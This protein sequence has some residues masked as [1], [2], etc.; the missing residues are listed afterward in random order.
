MPGDKVKFGVLITNQG[1]EVA[2]GRIGVELYASP[3]RVLGAGDVRVGRTGDDGACV[4]RGLTPG[5]LR[6]AAFTDRSLPSV[7]E[8]EGVA[9]EVA[10]ADVRL[11]VFV[12]PEG[13][14][15]KDPTQFAETQ[16]EAD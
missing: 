15:L 2:V 7:V 1:D 5:R 3:D 8:T 9:G 16:L 6:V 12:K 10:A 11:Q 14:R 4:V 13:Q